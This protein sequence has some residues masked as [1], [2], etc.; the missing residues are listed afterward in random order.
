MAAK[1]FGQVTL[2]CRTEQAHP[3][4]LQQGYHFHT[5]ARGAPR[6]GGA[7]MAGPPRTHPQPV[8]GMTKQGEGTQAPS[9][10]ERDAVSGVY[11]HPEGEASQTE[12]ETKSFRERLALLRKPSQVVLT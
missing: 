9:F 5:H 7:E 1:P 11:V 8:R 12:G 3:S 10:G 2:G 6:P 4:T